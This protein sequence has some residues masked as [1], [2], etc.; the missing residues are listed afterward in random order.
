MT[1][2]Q[3]TGDT[4]WARMDRA[5]EKVQE[6]MA[7]AAQAL[8]QSEIPYAIVGGNAVPAWVSQ[9]DEAAVRNTPDVDILLR[10]EDLPRAIT[11][12]G[13]VGF[14]HRKAAGT[15]TFLDGADAKARDAVHVVIAG[16]KVREE[17]VLPLPDPA[18]MVLLNDFPVISLEALTRMKL[19]SFRDKDRMHLRDMLDVGLIDGSWKERLPDPLAARL[20]QL[21]D[22]P[23]G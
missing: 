22:D 15:E 18:D 11:A 20:Q 1:A 16:E 19:N 10:R 14:V 8:K 3:F 9:V 5:V 17:Y 12:L 13:K 4:W 2:I 6:R 21:I 7:R 23:D